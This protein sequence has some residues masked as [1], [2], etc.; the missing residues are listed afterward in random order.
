MKKSTKYTLLAILT[1]GIVLSVGYLLTDATL[2]KK[3][4][5]YYLIVDKF[6][7]HPILPFY[8]RLLAMILLV[9]AIVFLYRDSTLLKKEIRHREQ[10]EKESIEKGNE[11]EKSLALSKATL[12]AT[13]DGILVVDANR[14]FAGHNKQFVEM[15]KVPPSI[16]G[17]G[18]DEKAVNHIL[19]QLK[20]PNEF[21][22]G[23]ERLYKAEPWAEH[24]DEILFKDGRIFERYTKPQMQGDEIIGRVFSFRDVTRRKEMEEQLMYQAT[25]DSLTAL[26]NRVILLDRINQELK[27]SKRSKNIGA[28]LFFDLDQFKLVNDGLGH[29]IGD[30]LLQAVARRLEHCI[31]EQDTVARWGGDEFVILLTDLKHENEAIPVAIKCLKVLEESFVIDKHT[32]SITSSVGISFLPKD[33]KTTMTLLKNADSAMYYAKNEGRNNYKV[34]TQIMGAYTKKQLEL[35]NEL[36]EAVKSNQLMVYYQPL[37]DLRDGSITGAE[38]LLRWNHP[39]LGFIAPQDFIPVAEDTG[40][41]LAMGEWV[42]RMACLQAKSWQEKGFPALTMAINL[43]GRQFKQ[44]NIPEIVA[45]IIK[46]TKIEAQYIELELTESVIMDNTQAFLEYMHE[47]KAMGV[48]LVIDDFGTGYSSLSYL[49]RFPVDTLKIDLSF[50]AGIPGSKDDTAIVRAILAMA[51][52]LHLDVVA[53]GI[54]TENQLSFLTDNFCQRGQGFL[55][56]EAVP[57]DEFTNLLKKNNFKSMF[58]HKDGKKVS[59]VKD[60]IQPSLV[61]S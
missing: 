54:E 58:E 20:D 7:M 14:K 34:Y 43:S 28:V 49:K 30:I 16:L 33:G 61:I 51:K 57:S 5:S 9:C 11:L 1:G 46:E 12:E 6:F 4:L 22:A 2:T 32:L 55:F 41:I 3:I 15:W 10:I 26:A 21:I 56:S 25:H 31:R 52:Q 13:A 40:L 23:L 39:T 37:V 36:H 24:L 19:S 8:F 18:N 27:T 48:K 59:V 47:L 50:I 44:K 38:A 60:T 53:E 17:P 42:L 29:D 45:K 35:T